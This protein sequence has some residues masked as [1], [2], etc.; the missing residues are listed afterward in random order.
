MRFLGV[1]VEE[2]MDG[3]KSEQKVTKKSR[4]ADLKRKKYSLTKKQV[5]SILC[6][7]LSALGVLMQILYEAV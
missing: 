2:L 7:V 3:K 6:L 5:L 4:I 1:T